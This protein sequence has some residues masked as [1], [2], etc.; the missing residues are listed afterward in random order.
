MKQNRICGSD[1]HH[2]LE[3]DIEQTLVFS[4]ISSG[5]PNCNS[6]NTMLIYKV[7]NTKDLNTPKSFKTVEVTDAF[8]QVN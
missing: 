5:E 4:K 3:Y 8:L 1:T 6:A 2:L 7:K